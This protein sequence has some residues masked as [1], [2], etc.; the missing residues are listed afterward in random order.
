[1]VFFGISFGVHLIQYRV[2]NFKWWKLMK[3]NITRFLNISTFRMTKV[4]ICMNFWIKINNVSIITIYQFFTLVGRFAQL[5][6]FI[7]K[8]ENAIFWIG[9][10]LYVSLSISIMYCKSTRK[11]FLIAILWI[12]FRN[13]Y[14]FE[15]IFQWSKIFI[16]SF[17][18]VHFS[19]KMKK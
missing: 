7:A 2:L 13:N 17:R 11:S 12:F 18:S 9:N 4:R 19:I 1:M 3:L 10:S 15:F 5:I 8:L 6:F 14:W 16:F